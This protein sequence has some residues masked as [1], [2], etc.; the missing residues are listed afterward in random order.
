MKNHFNPTSLSASIVLGSALVMQGWVIAF[1]QEAVPPAVEQ[2]SEQPLISAAAPE[3]PKAEPVFKAVE[4]YK[5]LFNHQQVFNRRDNGERIEPIERVT[6]ESAEG[7]IYTTSTDGSWV[8]YRLTD[9]GVY[10]DMLRNSEFESTIVLSKPWL[11]FPKEM[12]VG[13]QISATIP[14][15]LYN[16]K[17][18]ARTGKVEWSATYTG[19]AEIETPFKT[20]KN[21]HK[22]ESQM[23]ID[24]PYKFGL[25]FKQT[26]YFSEEDGEVYRLIDGDATFAG[27]SIRDRE[28]V[29]SLSS[30]NQ[31]AEELLQST[32]NKL[33]RNIEGI[34]L[35]VEL[36]K[37]QLP[38]AV[39]T[40][41]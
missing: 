22:I 6:F 26:H 18:S 12:R 32:A 9:E 8:G 36:A 24:F 31:A 38:A 33:E 17:K 30:S 25:K 39:Q 23:N 20:Y 29:E 14:F 11:M 10:I 15:D 7:T 27:I 4:I 3:P 35:D 5:A 1:A 2:V 41:N 19:L 13:D 40:V 37:T 16:K 21:A 28:L 34:T